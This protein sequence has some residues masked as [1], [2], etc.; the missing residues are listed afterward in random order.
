MSY[1]RLHPTDAIHDGKKRSSDYLLMLTQSIL[2][3]TFQIFVIYALA[4]SDSNTVT[5]ACGSK[6]WNFVL[7]ELL[8]HFLEGVIFYKIHWLIVGSSPAPFWIAM[9]LIIH[10]IP[11]SFGVNIVIPA[12]EKAE[13]STAL[14]SVSFTSTPM[15][16][17]IGYIFV[18][19]DSIALVAAGCMLFATRTHY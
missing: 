10:I 3:P 6:L 19:L 5:D 8:F 13:C 15:L 16:G 7:A 2:Y 18:V 1:Q 9:M 14:S 12:M 17:I 11:L 4:V